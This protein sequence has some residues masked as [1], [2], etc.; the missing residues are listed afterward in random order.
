MRFFLHRTTPSWSRKKL[1]QRIVLA[2]DVFK[3]NIPSFRHL[4]LVSVF[5]CLSI[6]VLPKPVQAV[7]PPDLIV[8][9]GAQVAGVFSVLVA[10]L[11]SALATAGVFFLG[12][13]QWCKQW[14]VYI[15]FGILAV[16]LVGSNAFLMYMLNQN[17]QSV[18]S[19]PVISQQP[20]EEIECDWCQFYSDSITLFV[21]GE[22][23]PAVIELDLNRRQETDG[24]YSH[25]YFLDGFIDESNLDL[26]TQFNSPERTM[27]PYSYLSQIQRVEP[28]DLSV[29]A[30]YS[31]DIEAADG[32]QISFTTSQ[33]QGDFVTRSTPEYTQ[34]Q[35]PA[36]A[37]LQIDGEDITAY[38][39]VESLHSVDYTQWI[40]FPGYY[41]VQSKTHQFILWDAEGNFYMIDDSQV[42]SDTKAYPPHSWLL[43]KNAATTQT[44]KGFLTTISSVAEN[45][46]QVT[47]P[48]F[49]QGVITVEVTKTYQ[50]TENGRTRHI[51]SGVVK[52]QK[53]ERSI[54]GI[55]KIVE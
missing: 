14:S 9:A 46:W 44:Q 36:S 11:V 20:G 52:D 35:S 50:P 34:F 18:T 6:S 22:T 27:Q 17:Q 54:S 32:K 28:E 12:W 13:Y 19:V 7:L 30:V 33:L 15:A 40:F 49:N 51:V 29:R 23:N 16:A 43:Y 26:Y 37:Q 3:R 25:Y 10:V 48:D 1:S 24:T 45:Q 31:G 47:V 38:A 8:S 4:L 21:P 2:N 41:S 53:G 42:F 39:L 55:L 5:L